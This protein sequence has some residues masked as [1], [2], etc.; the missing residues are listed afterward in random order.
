[1]KQLSDFPRVTLGQLP[2]P[3]YRLENLSRE[4]GKNLFIKRDDMTGVSLGGNKVRKLEYL[5]A[6]ALE[7]GCDTVLT[8]GAAQS[9]HAMLTAA[10]ANRLGMRAILV[11]K[12][13]GV[14]DMRGNLVLDDIL[15]AEVR[16]V[17]S[18]N[19]DDVYAEM[20]RAAAQVEARG[21]KAYLVPVGGST[22]LGSL[23]YVGCAME[24]AEQARALGVK[25]DH[26][27]SCTG[28]GGTHAGLALGTKLFMFDAKMTGI[29]V[30]DE[31]FADSVL[32]LMRG[33]ASLLETP[34]VPEASD[35]RIQ[36]SFGPGYGKASPEGAAAIRLMARKEGILLDPVYSGKAFAGLLRLLEAG[37][38]DGEENI[39]FVHTGGA[40]ALFAVDLPA[41]P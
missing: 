26:I 13:R 25:P 41:E 40:G 32:A 12:K 22:P 11:L 6:D 28:S 17:D 20:R 9:N 14:S 31:P 21:R 18:D 30:S 15:G 16:L 2:T 24:I 37:Y 38:F 36:Y 34:V 35:V 29:G 33:A 23:G 39:V 8:V 5:L 19:Y 10:C 27:V 4:L 7:K 1:M 3:F